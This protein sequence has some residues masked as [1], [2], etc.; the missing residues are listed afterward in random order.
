VSLTLV[1]IFGPGQRF[2]DLY[3]SGNQRSEGRMGEA[4]RA[5]GAGEMH[6]RFWWGGLK[7]AISKT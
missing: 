3:S 7:E 6:A 4:Y 1:E 2:L 5:Y